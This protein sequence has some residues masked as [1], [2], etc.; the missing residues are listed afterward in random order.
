MKK[1][2]ESK[3][4]LEVRT[5]KKKAAKEAVKLCGQA[6][7]DYYNQSIKNWKVKKAA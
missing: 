5:W 7:L 3:A 1:E 4:L 2:T 6:R